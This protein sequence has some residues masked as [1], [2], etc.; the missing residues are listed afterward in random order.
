MLIKY[1]CAAKTMTGARCRYLVEIPVEKQGP[2]ALCRIHSQKEKLELAS[3][4]D[5]V[6]VRFKVNPRWYE[7]LLRAGIELR[8]P[9]LQGRKEIKHIE[10]AKLHGRAP[11]RY[12]GRADSGTPV[13]GEKGVN[14]VGWT[15]AWSEML[16][17]GYGVKEVFLYPREERMAT[18]T[19]VLQRKGTFVTSGLRRRELYRFMFG[20][21]YRYL[22]VWANPPT[23]TGE[24]IHTLNFAQRI[25]HEKPKVIL[26]F[27]KGLWAIKINE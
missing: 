17:Q 25:P 1:A 21:V 26:S 23:D 3:P 9:G 19:I 24:I 8:R 2:E 22:H 5:V 27:N 16:N 15:E 7:R 12:R 20:A 13:F 6:L 11:Y 18:L 10:H 14:Y 4:P